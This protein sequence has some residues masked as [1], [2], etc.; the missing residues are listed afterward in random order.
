LRGG[1]RGWVH[2]KGESLKTKERERSATSSDMVK[3]PLRKASKKK[4]ERG[5]QKRKEKLGQMK[6]HHES[7]VHHGPRRK[8][9]SS[10]EAKEK[11]G[12]PP[13]GKTS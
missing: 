12:E 6:V 3:K 10:P 7:R 4:K 9:K 13:A 2:R 11:G 1:V 5:G 8:G